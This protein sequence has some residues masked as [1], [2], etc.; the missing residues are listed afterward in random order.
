MVTMMHKIV[1]LQ[2]DKP[3]RINYE[4]SIPFYDVDAMCIAWHGHYVKYFEDAR[5]ALLDSIDY[6]YMIMG[7]TGYS[8]PIIDLQIKYAHP[9]QFGQRIII[10][11]TI[12]D[13]DNGLQIVYEIRDKISGQRLTRGSTR[14]VAVSFSD[15]EMQLC[16][17]SIL[18]EKIAAYYTKEQQNE[19]Q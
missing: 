4:H 6:N 10:T 11:A 1:E 17:P 14:Q 8:W 19:N 13:I 7:K 12:K 16:S 2:A 15:G 3:I 5:C 18:Y 9:L